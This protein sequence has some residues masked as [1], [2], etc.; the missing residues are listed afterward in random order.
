MVD[1]GNM[2][3]HFLLIGGETNRRQDFRMGNKDG[4]QKILQ[5]VTSTVALN[6]LNLVPNLLH[7][8]IMD[9]IQIGL[10]LPEGTFGLSGHGLTG[11][12]Q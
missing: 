10:E 9:L 2:N 12:F 3:L 8:P 11:G 7:V 1:L 6:G 4:R 5:I